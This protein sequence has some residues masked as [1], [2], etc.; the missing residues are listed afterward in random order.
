MTFRRQERHLEGGHTRR[1]HYQTIG[2]DADPDQSHAREL[3]LRDELV[4]FVHEHPAP[5]VAQPAFVYVPLFCG[6]AAARLDGVNIETAQ[7][8]AR[9]VNQ[10]RLPPAR[11]GPNGRSGRRNWRRWAWAGCMGPC[12]PARSP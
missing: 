5:V 8:D 4:G 3:A 2:V 1:A 10:T 12:Y 6:D 9:L 11:G 7:A